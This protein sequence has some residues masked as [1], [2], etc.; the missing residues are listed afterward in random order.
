MRLR[1]QF[2][3]AMVFFCAILAV[4]AA[5]TIIINQKR[6]RARDQEL[7]AAGIAGGASELSYLAHDYLIYGEHQQLRRWQS[8]FASF[9]GQVDFLRVENPPQRALV[10]DMQA[11]QRRLKEVFEGAVAARKFAAGTAVP[12]DPA[13]LQV[14]WSRIAVQTQSL[15]SNATQL[16]KLLHRRMDELNE[17]RTM[18]M[19]VMLGLMGLILLVSYMLTYRR[20]LGSIRALQ[21]GTKICRLRQP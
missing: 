5:S 4:V 18:L 11:N 1:T 12:F 16:S 17:T 15:V 19:Y 2:L 21:T 13:L 14:S 20:I 3:A 6:D 10:A 9:S 8:R 7:I